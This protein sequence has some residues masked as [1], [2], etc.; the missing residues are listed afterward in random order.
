MER[1]IVSGYFDREM[2]PLVKTLFK[3]RNA[4]PTSSCSG[5]LLILASRVPWRKRNVKILY[6]VHEIEDSV[7]RAILERLS[8]LEDE[9]VWLFVQPPI[10]HVSCYDYETAEKLVKIG[11]NAGFKE[12][13]IFMKSELGLHVELKGRELLVVPVKLE[14]TLL[15]EGGRLEIVVDEAA[16]ILEDF[17]TKISKFKSEVEAALEKGF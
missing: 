7:K 4:Y 8:N 13:K 14:K 9:N 1:D 2:I 16:R 17:K 5:R 15:L 10:V 12:S 3:L 11:R 6:K